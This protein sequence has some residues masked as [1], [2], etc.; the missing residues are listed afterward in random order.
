MGNRDVCLGFGK[1]GPSMNG[2]KGDF[3]PFIMTAAKAAFSP[4]RKL[5]RSAHFV[6]MAE[7]KSSLR[8]TRR[9]ALKSVG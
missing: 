7:S 5:L 9:S 6:L 4:F 1:A 3:W 2:V 8:F